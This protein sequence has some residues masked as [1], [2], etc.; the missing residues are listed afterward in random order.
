[1]PFILLL[2]VL[3]ISNINLVGCGAFGL[4]AFRAEL[5]TSLK[6]YIYKLG[7]I[8]NLLE[9]S[10]QLSILI[11]VLVRANG[12]T[13]SGFASLGF[14]LFSLLYAILKFAFLSMVSRE[15][16]VSGE[17]EMAEIQNQKDA[18]LAQA[19]RERAESRTRAQQRIDAAAA[20]KAKAEDQAKAGTAKLKAEAAKTEAEAKLRA[21]ARR[22]AELERK[23]QQ[24]QAGTSNGAVV[25]PGAEQREEVLN[26]LTVE[27]A[28]HEAD[29]RVYDN[30]GAPQD[31]QAA[32]AGGDQQGNTGRT[33]KSFFGFMR[34][35]KG[36]ARNAG[37]EQPP[38]HA[39]PVG[40]QGG[41][42]AEA[43]E[44]SNPSQFQSNPGINTGGAESDTDGVDA[45]DTDKGS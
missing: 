12:L 31:E 13:T 26:P 36:V 18:E 32:T 45:P 22:I 41:V 44:V 33:R 16:T 21:Q 17:Y 24:A 8:D 38:L 30:P 4:Q 14:T 15:H 29:T 2:G 40:G 25:Q 43:H 3:N 11:S 20:E 19:E 10:T 39:A 23:L 42:E 7:A 35:R 27:G 9:D 34:V 1:M 28:M 5:P 37:T 6:L